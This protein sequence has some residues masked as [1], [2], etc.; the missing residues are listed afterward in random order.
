MADLTQGEIQGTVS[1]CRKSSTCS[2]ICLALVLEVKMSGATTCG[3]RDN[4]YGGV[5]TT[6]LVEVC[7]TFSMVQLLLLLVAATVTAVVV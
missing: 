4:S 3:G 7:I 2:R 5:L 6:S 1:S